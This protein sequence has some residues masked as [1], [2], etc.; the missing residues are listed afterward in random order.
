MR[1]KTPEERSLQE[2]RDFL[3]GVNLHTVCESAICPNVGACFTG[4]TAT[5]IILVDVSTRNFSFC[6]SK[7]DNPLLPDTAEPHLL[8]EE[9]QRLTFENVVTAFVTHDTLADGEDIP[10]VQIMLDVDCDMLTTG[11]ISGPWTL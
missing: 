10:F 8:G 3:N 11:N 9:A 2:M 7:H 6:S 4:V 1:I 5:F